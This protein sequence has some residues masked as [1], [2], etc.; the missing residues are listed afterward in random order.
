MLILGP[1]DLHN[2][3]IQKMLKVRTNLLLRKKGKSWTPYL[4]N[5]MKRRNRKRKL[6]CLRENRRGNLRIIKTRTRFNLNI[7]RNQKTDLAKG[8]R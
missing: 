1:T 2:Q 6:H 4:L 8:N 3:K 7:K 5:Q